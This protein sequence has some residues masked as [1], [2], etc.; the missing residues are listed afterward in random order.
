M[1]LAPNKQLDTVI[2]TTPTMA[3]NDDNHAFQYLVAYTV[4]YWMFCLQVQ[5]PL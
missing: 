4:L 2:T 3:C 5:A 1:V